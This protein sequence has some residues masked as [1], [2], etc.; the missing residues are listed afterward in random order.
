MNTN[1]MPNENQDSYYEIRLKGHLSDRWVNRF[2]DVSISLEQHGVT[3][4]TI[5]I[6]DQA[7]LFGLLKQVRDAGLPLISVNPIESGVNTTI[8][9][10]PVNQIQ[11]N[12]G[13]KK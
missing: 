1:N 2:D 9:E 10:H 5:H 3:L 4:L 6:V 13:D 8:E 12:K 7:A 11:S